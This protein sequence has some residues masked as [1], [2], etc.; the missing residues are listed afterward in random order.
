MR[1]R[2]YVANNAYRP[3]GEEQE[4]DNSPEA[5]V[6]TWTDVVIDCFRMRWNGTR[7]GPIRMTHRVQHYTGE[8]KITDLDYYPVRFRDNA[9][10][11]CEQLKLR[12]KAV[13]D[14]HGHKKYDWLAAK[15]PSE[16][17]RD[18]RPR[19]PPPPGMRMVHNDIVTEMGSAERELESDVYVD[20]KTFS[21]KFSNANSEFDNLGRVRPST[22]EVTESSGM[23]GRDRDYHSGDHDVDEARSDSFLSSNF[24]L[25]HSKRPKDLGDMQDYLMLLPRTVPGF[26]F[27]QRQ[28]GKYCPKSFLSFCLEGNY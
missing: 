6:G 11:L 24:H 22:R 23:G 20:F 14:C 9:G 21:Q 2:K 4:A 17:G 19:P 10:E 3:P 7:V 8:K 15:G 25:T 5:G 28:W 18:H 13:L 1:L 26:E 16:R 27:R 12:G